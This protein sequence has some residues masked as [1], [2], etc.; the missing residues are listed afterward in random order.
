[1]SFDAGASW[2]SLQLNLPAAPVHDLLVKDAAVVI[3]THGRSFWI[4]DDVAPLR[5]ITTEVTRS[6]VHLFSVTPTYRLMGRR[7]ASV[8]AGEALRVYGYGRA[9]G[10]AV[11][12]REV[13]GPNGEIKD[14][15]ERIKT[16][17][18]T[19]EAG[20]TRVVGRNP[21]H[22]PPKGLHQKLATLT[23]AIGNADGAPTRW[24]YTVVE[25][26]SA[27]L[28]EHVKELNALVDSD[29]TPFLK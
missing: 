27:R 8:R 24:T 10:D 12:F 4:L 1:M 14:A 13:E 9:A 20:L 22:L 28:A 21:M 17:L 7:S 3:G 18:A 23:N 16:R 15:A 6:S 29:L 26:L 11:A 19:I 5:Q 2:Q 25:E